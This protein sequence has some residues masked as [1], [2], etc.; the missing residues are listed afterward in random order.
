MLLISDT[1]IVFVCNLYLV[2]YREPLTKPRSWG[3][4][5]RHRTI[6]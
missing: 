4:V 2:V 5:N 3:I 6:N 1:V